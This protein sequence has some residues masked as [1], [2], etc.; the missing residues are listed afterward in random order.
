[1]V[2]VAWLFLCML[3]GAGFGEG[4][5]GE[6][7]PRYD[8]PNIVFM[9]A[10]D[11]GYGDVG[12]NGGRAD[13]PNLDAMAMGS[14]SILLTRYYSG[15]PVCSP[16]RG[17]VLT[18]RNHNR[19]CVW[20]ANAGNECD[21]FE[22]PETMPLPTSEITIADILEKNGYQTAIFGKWH[23]GDLKPLFGGNQKWPV[24]HPGMHG[25]DK[26]WVTERSAPTSNLNCACFN[27]S[28]CPRGHYTD[29][30]PCT[31]YYTQDP[32]TELLV[33]FAQ[34][35]NG[36]DSH[37]ILKEFSTFL[38]DV[39]Q[40]GEPFFVYLPFHTVH[41]RYIATM[42]YIKRYISRGYS[43]EETDY[44]GALTAMDDVV[45]QIRALLK[46]YNVSNNTMLWFTSDNG[47]EDDQ[48]GVTAGFRGRKHTLWE[49]GI[50]V[51]GIIEWPDMIKTN[52]K[53]DFPV[54]SSDLLPTV[55]DILGVD[56]PQDRPIDGISVLPFINGQTSSRNKSIAW[57]FYIPGDF[58]GS[59]SAVLSGDQYKVYVNYSSGEAVA[60]YLFDLINDPFETQ[61]ISSLHPD[62]YKAM[63][64]EL[65]TW[66]LS[67]I[68]SA[69]KEVGCYGYSEVA[70][71][72]HQGYKVDRSQ[73]L[74]DPQK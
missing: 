40:N 24:S 63:A 5:P 51:P 72:P 41:I 73:S 66:R 11:M 61:D 60:G 9:M 16:T 25:F 29:D 48:P 7:E 27:T 53:S 20:T 71:Y 49:G 43:L 69:E 32:D 4:R 31:N 37:F 55:C 54:V 26:W 47:P 58:N 36:D 45:G 33:T 38:D 35:I 14:N 67:V 17:T 59:Y 50:R 6:Q 22:C 42:G 18:G 52:V 68:Q 65:E 23:L 15:G 10:D 70:Q 56:P 3:A 46:Q 74:M 44:Y 62:I 34:P 39:A 64:A 13:T 8:L 12:Y 30:P 28:M 2:V 21:D 1:M 19:Y 57:A